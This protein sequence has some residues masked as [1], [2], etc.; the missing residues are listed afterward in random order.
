MKRAK[1]YVRVFIKL[2]MFSAVLF[3][4][5]MSLKLGILSGILAGIMFGTCFSVIMAMIFI[6]IDYLSTRKYPQEALSLRQNREL[7]IRGDFEPIFEKSLDILKDLKFIKTLTP[8][9]EKMS[10]SARTRL[11]LASFGEDIRL[12]FKVLEKGVVKIHISSQSYGRYTL[13]DFGKNYR[14]VERI[15]ERLAALV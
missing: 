5:L 4:S 15:K 7:Q 13:L 6:P 9:K 2:G 12:E 10:I 14:N 3:G 11:S 8:E 1:K